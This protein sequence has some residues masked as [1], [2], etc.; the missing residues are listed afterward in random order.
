MECYLSGELIDPSAKGTAWVASPLT[1]WWSTKRLVDVTVECLVGWNVVWQSGYMTKKGVTTMTDGIGDGWKT[2]YLSDVFFPDEYVPFDL[3][4]LPLT[5][6]M[7][8][9]EGSGIGREKRL[10]FRLHIIILTAPGRGK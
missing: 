6:D 10:M 2:S 8:G 4:Q 9:L 5:L 7:K 1:A 3:Q